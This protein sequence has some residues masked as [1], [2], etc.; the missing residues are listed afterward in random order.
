MSLRPAIGK[1]WLEK[2]HKDVYP[3]DQVIFNGIPSRPPK[4]YDQQLKKNNPEIHEEIAWQRYKITNMED[5]T[6]ERLK[7]RET[8]KR[9]KDQSLKRKIL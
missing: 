5:K 3:S 4:Y 6:D 1:K 7:V 9:A 2:Y 8:V